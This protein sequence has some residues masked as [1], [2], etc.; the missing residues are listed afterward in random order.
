MLSFQARSLLVLSLLPSY[1]DYKQISVLQS[2]II[3]HG[4]LNEGE[5]NT[6]KSSHYP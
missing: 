4:S 1:K 5:K 6:S 2:W 3:R